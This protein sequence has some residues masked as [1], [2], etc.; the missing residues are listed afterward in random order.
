MNG[1]RSALIALS[2][3]A[4]AGCPSIST[5]GTARTI[6]EGTYQYSVAG[7]YAVMSDTVVDDEGNPDSVSAPSLE[8][9][10]RYGISDRIEVGG[11]IFPVGAELGMKAQVLRSASTD[12]GLDLAVAPSLSVYPWSKGVAGWGNLSI[13]LGFNVGGGN[14][15]VLSPRGT[16]FL[17]TSEEGSGSVFMAGGSMGFAVKLKPGLTLLPEV[18]ALVPFSQSLPTDVEAKF[19]FEG[20]LFQ[21]SVGVL[22]GP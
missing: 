17:V 2:A 7:G 6:P 14:Q 10:I 4:L 22:F 13:P 15:L 21:G 8:L 3:F 9:G 11:K 19:A 18:S 1:P 20:P 5:M 12:R 16:M